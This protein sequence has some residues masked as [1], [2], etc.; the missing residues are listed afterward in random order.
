MNEVKRKYVARMRIILFILLG[1]TFAGAIY[2]TAHNFRAF[3]IE[4]K[5]T[6]SI[7]LL[8][9]FLLSILPRFRNSRYSSYLAII[10]GALFLIYVLAAIFSLYDNYVYSQWDI[11]RRDD[12]K[13]HATEVGQKFNHEY[14]KYLENNMS[15]IK[16]D[17]ELHALLTH[18][19]NTANRRSIFVSLRKKFSEQKPIRNG[20]GLSLLTPEGKIIAWYGNTKPL[21][22]SEFDHVLKTDENIFTYKSFVNTWLNVLAVLK[23][24]QQN[25]IGYAL[26]QLL[27]ESSYNI[28]DESAQNR[29]NV[30]LSFLP[31]RERISIDF[32]DFREEVGDLQALFE[33]HGSFVW[34]SSRGE[35]ERLYYPLYSSDKDI[36][37]VATVVSL[38]R[39]SYVNH[40]GSKL[41][42]TAA[43]VIILLLLWLTVLQIKAYRTVLKATNKPHLLKKA[44]KSLTS[45][46][47]LLFLLWSIRWLF[48]Y[49]NFPL[50][51]MHSST[52]EPRYFM[53]HGFLQL[54]ISPADFLLTSFFFFMSMLF[55][56]LFFWEIGQKIAPL[57]QNNNK[58][59]KLKSIRALRLFSSFLLVLLV[60][61]LL[62][63]FNEFIST[64]AYNSGAKIIIFSLE[65]PNL[66]RLCIGLGI[67]LFALSFLVLLCSTFILFRAI[68]SRDTKPSPSLK[69]FILFSASII[70]M[71]LLINKVILPFL[72]STLLL[73]VIISILA[74]YY[75]QILDW[76]HRSS[77]LARIIF[78]F[79]LAF[80]SIL[81]Y[82]PGIF[83]YLDELKINF[84]EKELIPQIENQRDYGG[85]VLR[86]S[87]SI[88][89]HSKRLKDILKSVELESRGVAYSFWREMGFASVE[90][91]SSLSVFDSQGKLIDNFS[92]YFPHFETKNLEELKHYIE[93]DISLKWLLFGSRQMEVIQGSKTILDNGEII[94]AVNVSISTGYDNLAF[95]HS[96]DP[97][98][99]I[100]HPK[101]FSNPERV[102]F[103][104]QL[105]LTVYE[106]NRRI[107]FSSANKIFSI[108]NQ[109]IK[110]LKNRKPLIWKKLSF[111]NEDYR[112]VY[113]EALDSPFA[114]GFPLLS[115]KDYIFS[116]TGLLAIN[117][118]I[119]IFLYLLFAIFMA[120]IQHLRINWFNLWEGISKSFYRK[121]LALLILIS[122]IPMIF[123][124]LSI[125]NYLS[126]RLMRQ[127]REEG[128]ATAE[129]A[130]RAME[131]YL[132]AQERE[133]DKPEDL[134]DDNLALLISSW[135][136]R[137]IHIFINDYLVATN[138]RELFSAGFISSRIDDD[139]YYQLALAKQPYYTNQYTLGDF[140]YLVINVP[141]ELPAINK[142][143]ILSTPLMLEQR[144]VDIEITEINDAIFIAT[145]LLIIFCSVL[146]YSIARKVSG[147]IKKLTQSTYQISEGN[148]D[149][150]VSTKSKDE[151]KELVESFNLM[152]KN[153]KQQQ[154]ALRERKEYIEQILLN[155]PTGVLSL[156]DKGMITTINPSAVRLLLIRQKKLIGLPFLRIITNSRGLKEL[157]S[158]LMKYLREPQKQ[159]SQEIQIERFG[160]KMSL[161]IKFLPLKEREKEISGSIILIE[162]I[163]DVINSNRLATWA[164]M[165]RII[166]HEIKNPLTP[167][168]LSAEHLKQV[169][170]DQPQGYREISNAC[171]E[172][173][174]NQVSLLRQ[175]STEFSRYAKFPQLKLSA[176]NIKELINNVVCS[177][178]SLQRDKYELKIHI[179][180][181]LPLIKGDKELLR[182]V[183]T[184]IIENSLEAMPDGGT[185]TINAKLSRRKGL[186]GIK[187]EISDSGTGIDEETLKR[188]FEP[189]FSTKDSGVGLG[190]A[191]SKKAIEEHKGEISVTSSPGKGT[192]I[193][194]W[195]PEEN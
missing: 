122:I 41:Q 98:Y 182:R 15:L 103:N 160:N 140:S 186:K 194:I 36:L 39:E 126:D 79:L 60:A 38:D 105:F 57:E 138:K 80:S 26:A 34:R 77:L 192:K 117:G 16:N 70:F 95:V 4:I 52:F 118:I 67:H 73:L 64:V 112:L 27:L 88:L 190:L 22:D 104:D 162:D 152:A 153:V 110:E 164:E 82:Y 189:Y 119:L 125:R 121:I 195:L 51:L 55:A 8:A 143:T 68:N 176:L 48:S 93:P 191:I 91:N 56:G 116:I 147:P 175:L 157:K 100:F 44:V 183:F 59:F 40:F 177:Y 30:L 83:T 114:I 178:S 129:F 69:L 161:R 76:F 148:F 123:L 141:I 66:V 78:L 108:D 142:S 32:Y 193:T 144:Q 23:D 31:E 131:D 169:I 172:S 149:L 181:K 17:E 136:N 109:T 89:D 188:L 111:D 96:N 150:Q 25:V 187:I 120:N 49:L 133:K 65:S 29:T 37:G 168:Q 151:M 13:K 179:E 128:I 94:G 137:D 134:I 11:L 2:D 84:V 115:L 74:Y 81:L 158:L 75:H 154:L 46:V 20:F 87:F 33:R 124:S 171:I 72:L 165:A 35:S 9:G 24:K 54:M 1:A 102:L 174:L 99:E 45:L 12:M 107:I 14:I 47:I 18:D 6:L 19:R 163:T 42:T 58:K 159:L 90:F 62:S 28:N 146:S 10:M 50:Q 85:F 167:I 185:L 3:T 21:G 5:I 101:R 113:F 170:K 63:Q 92:F 139:I 97:Y 61:F 135:A 166:A 145:V 184:N 43:L 180:E 71:L 127:I 86:Q 132:F 106:W 7:L 156:D 130:K 53:L 173:I 155:A